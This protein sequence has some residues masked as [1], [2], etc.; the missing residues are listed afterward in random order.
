MALD[1]NKRQQK[2]KCAESRQLKR[3][4]KHRQLNTRTAAHLMRKESRVRV[5]AG[6]AKKS[7]RPT[8]KREES[9]DERGAGRSTKV[10]L[11]SSCLFLI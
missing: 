5:G 9:I 2:P 8:N 7:A 1:P 11:L 10:F 6:A 3:E 4:A